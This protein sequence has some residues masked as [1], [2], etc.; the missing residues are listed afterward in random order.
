MLRKTFG[1]VAYLIRCRNPNSNM[2][3]SVSKWKEAPLWQSDSHSS[4]F[5]I[6]NNCY[7]NH[8]LVHSSNLIL[9]SIFFCVREQKALINY[10][11]HKWDLLK[12]FNNTLSLMSARWWWVSV[13][14]QRFF[15]SPFWNEM[16]HIQVVTQTK[17]KHQNRRS[18][19]NLLTRS[20][21]RKQFA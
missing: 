18:W 5:K 6:R 16:I 10:C 21:V 15:L 4:F 8:H 13:K 1:F 14:I 19:S 3:W 11:W 17:V 20:E 2:I 7:N 9:I 12:D